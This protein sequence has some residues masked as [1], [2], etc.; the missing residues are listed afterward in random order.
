[1]HPAI[2]YD[3]RPLDDRVTRLTQDLA[4]GKTTLTAGTDGYLPSLL[5]ALDVNP[6][7][8]ALV[9]SKTSFQAARIE[10]RNPRALY[11]SDDVTVGFVRG[12]SL[13]ELAALDPRQG[14]VFYSFDGSA[15]PPRFD[16]RDA[17]LQCH[18][19]PGTLGIP[20]LLTASSYTDASG[21]PAFRG[22][23][24]I[25][26][27]RTRFEDRWGGWYVTGTH[28]D[29]RHI[30]NAVGHDPAHPELLDMRDTQNVTSLA[31]RFDVHGYLSG[32]SDIVAL[33]TLE[34]QTRMTNL[35]IRTGWEARMAAAGEGDR[36]QIQALQVQLDTDLEA[37][38]TYM[39]FADEA[40]LFGP[41]TGVSTFT[42]TFPER[43]PR[44]R[45]GRS[46]RDFDLDRRLFR[47]PLSYMV[48]SETFDALPEQV[49]ERV[50]RRL[51]DVLTGT[52]QSEKFK[53]LSPAD[54]R[55]VLEILR[56]TK[57]GLPAYFKT[58]TVGAL[59]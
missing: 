57:P 31:K 32:L 23:Q 17:C 27:H 4:S 22:A 54:R 49:R 44:D 37:L 16:R 43:G 45:Q 28:A 9:F 56:E 21:M 50:Y 36:M 48:Y 6:D 58:D 7:S 55:A 53:R 2:Q 40:P 15:N 11:F 51:Y 14:V 5:Q 46:L 39:L 8:Q 12:S 3:Q 52:D 47:Y 24:R 42:K 19:S 38:V 1:D 10:P 59:R 13:L 26:D 41:V 18:H 30:G 33:M 35:M 34:H 29:M 25:T 20:G